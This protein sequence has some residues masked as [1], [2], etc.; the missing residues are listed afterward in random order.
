[1]SWRLGGRDNPRY[2]A[3]SAAEYPSSSA[4]LHAAERSATAAFL[5]LPAAI[6]L[7]GIM[8]GSSLNNQQK[9]SIAET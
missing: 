7:S 4:I 6:A 1:M 3:T 5:R 2:L 8:E 9:L